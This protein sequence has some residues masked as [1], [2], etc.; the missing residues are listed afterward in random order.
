MW[1]GLLRVALMFGFTSNDTFIMAVVIFFHCGMLVFPRYYTMRLLNIITWML[2]QE[3]EF[4]NCMYDF[5]LL[6]LLV[7]IMDVIF[8]CLITRPFFEVRSRCQWWIE[9]PN[10]KT[11]FLKLMKA[12]RKR[13]TKTMI[14]CRA[15]KGFNNY[16]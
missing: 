7:H 15:Y 4:T 10:Y 16:C 2:I 6:R 1:Q 14:F 13:A 5:E 9:E 11:H 8:V 3:F 12:G